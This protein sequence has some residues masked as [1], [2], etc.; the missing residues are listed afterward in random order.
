MAK[1]ITVCQ[2]VRLQL[3]MLYDGKQLQYPYQELQVLNKQ[4]SLL[5]NRTVQIAW[6]WNGFQQHFKEEHGR[7]PVQSEYINGRNDFSGYVYD[8]LKSEFSMLYS[9]NLNCTIRSA[10]KAFDESKAKINAGEQSV[11]SYRADCPLE[12]DGSAIKVTNEGQHYYVSIKAF[13]KEY[14][15]ERGY[16]Q[17]IVFSVHHPDGSRKAIIDRCNSGEYKIGASKL[18]WNKKKRCWFLNLAYSFT[19]EPSTSLRE[20]R[21][22]GV[23]LGIKCVAYMGVD[24]CDDRYFI[25]PSE[26]DAFRARTEARKRA[27][28]QQGKYCGEGRKGHGYQTRN[29]PVLKINDAIARFRDTANHKYSRYIV[30][31]AIKHG[32][33][34][35]QMEN[36]K[37][38]SKNDKF[39]K[40]WTYSDLQQKITY[41]AFAEGISVQYVNPSYTSQRCSR[42]GEINEA[43]RPKEEKGQAYFKCINCGF[44]TNADY[45]ASLNLAVKGIEKI[46][47]ETNRAKGKQ[48]HKG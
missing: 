27:L 34:T 20:D 29:K 30:D 15:K 4:V 45:N 36:L 38:V 2:V 47:Q 31:Q 41:K 9:S 22:M 37:G 39:L 35:I 48:T 33:G 44:E 21:V 19:K 1:K 14:R 17:S 6:E 26:V 43:N 28:Q 13:R 24:F 3:D 7:Y 25:G 11:L 18:I 12:I 16:P 5:K 42:C 40:D 23:D 32:C 8:A 46:I 10:I